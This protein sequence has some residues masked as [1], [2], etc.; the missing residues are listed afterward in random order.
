L[1]RVVP[2]ADLVGSNRV[3]H[4][5]N[6]PRPACWPARTGTAMDGPLDSATH[7]T[8]FVV[9]EASPTVRCLASNSMGT[10]PSPRIE[11]CRRTSSQTHRRGPN[12]TPDT[13][14]TRHLC[15]H[16]HRTWACFLSMGQ[17]H[18]LPRSQAPDHGKL[19]P[20]DLINSSSGAACAVRLRL[21]PARSA[22]PL[23]ARLPGPRL[24]LQRLGAALWSAL[25]CLAHL[26]CCI[27]ATAI[28][29]HGGRYCAADWRC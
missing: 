29:Q 6:P 2:L 3:G 25:H 7:P 22:V 14:P 21:H 24:V 18:R 11:H 28:P 16:L 4:R 1:Q 15:S 27:H 17:R 26:V 12:S 19:R 10:P 5:I 13:F 20:W 23:S 8:A 9:L